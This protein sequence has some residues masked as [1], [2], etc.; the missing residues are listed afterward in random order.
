MPETALLFA[1]IYDALYLSEPVLEEIQEVLH[2]PK[3]HRYIGEQRAHDIL[4][5]LLAGAHFVTPMMT[6]RACRDPADDKYLELAL[7]AGAHAIVT[8]DRDLLSMSPWRGIRI[9]NATDY[10][11][12][13]AGRE[14]LTG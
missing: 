9:L 4:A 6:V 3:F 8:G 1:L 13:I 5:L 14:G 12:M 2:R 10:V 7:T 11:A